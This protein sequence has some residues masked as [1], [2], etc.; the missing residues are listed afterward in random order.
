MSPRRRR[1]DRGDERDQRA[2]GEVG[3]VA[4][5]LDPEAEAPDDDSALDEVSEGAVEAFEEEVETEDLDEDELITLDDA[6]RAL[7]AKPRRGHGP[8]ARL[9]R[10]ETR[11]D[12]VG[13]RRVWFSISALII[14]LGIISIILRGGLNLGIEFKGGT[15]WTIA[16]PGVTQAQAA[17]AMKG[18]GV[19]D[20][21]VQL[22]GSGSKQTLTVQSDINRLSLA[23]QAAVSKNVQKAL[24][25]LTAAHAPAS[26]T[27]ATTTT[28]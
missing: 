4:E 21:T 7:L 20:P 16:A 13:R 14:A 24:L 2:A 9:Y 8:I 23:Q 1:R 22:L 19:I 3:D 18:T 28:A 12:F 17:D 26:S 5:D 6:A 27:A 11:F 15:E 10:G 25:D